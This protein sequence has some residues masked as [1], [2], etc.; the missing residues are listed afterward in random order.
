VFSGK[1]VTAL[2]GAQMV[3]TTLPC[4]YGWGCGWCVYEL[5]GFLAAYIFLQED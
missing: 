2:F 5:Q 1:K 3:P 4:S